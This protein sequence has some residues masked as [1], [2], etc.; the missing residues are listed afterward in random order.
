MASAEKLVALFPA[1]P[2]YR[3]LLVN[4]Y[5]G[6]SDVLVLKGQPEEARLV[7]ASVLEH[8]E[9][10]IAQWADRSDDSQPGVQALDRLLELGRVLCDGHELPGAEKAS[11]FVG[12]HERFAAKPK[13]KDVELYVSFKAVAGDEDQGGGFVW[14]YQDNN[15]YYICRM[16]V[17]FGPQT[18][19]VLP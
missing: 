1:I 19:G 11:R 3:Q 13:Y 15:N 2:D 16:N 18:K 17:I 7:R 12:T 9:M 4:C 14:R 5:L 10:L 8:T 6:L